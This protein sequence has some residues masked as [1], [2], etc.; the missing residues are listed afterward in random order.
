MVAGGRDHNEGVVV[1]LPEHALS[2]AEIEALLRACSR[3]APTGIRNAALIAV[4][5][6]C[7]LRLGEALDLWPQDVDLDDGTLIV[8][9]GKGGRRRVVGLDAGTCSLI[10][11]WL[12][13]R[14]VRVRSRSAPALLH[15]RR[16]TNRPATPPSGSAHHGGHVLACDL[17]LDEHQAN[18]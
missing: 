7:G 12:R 18:R 5:W 16:R 3:R 11:E 1:R 13:V 4:L 10:T 15:P 8:Q 9:H 14:A 6:R 17:H 2:S